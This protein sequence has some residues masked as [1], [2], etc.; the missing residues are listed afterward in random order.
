MNL[1]FFL[2]FA[3]C[4]ADYALQNDFVAQGKNRNTPVGRA[5]WYIVLPAHAMIHAG[6][7][8]LAT[9]SLTLGFLELILHSIIDFSKC[10]GKLTFGQD[11][12]L[13]I[14][15]KVIYVVLILKGLV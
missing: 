14:V 3:H 8:F 5:I 6:F 12:F 11:Q 13:H 9:Y 10:E 4:L 2:V 7:V 15:C 1:L